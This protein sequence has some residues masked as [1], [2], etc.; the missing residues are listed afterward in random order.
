[1]DERSTRTLGLIFGHMKLESVLDQILALKKA[2]GD[3]G[4]SCQIGD[5]YIDFVHLIDPYCTKKA[6]F[7]DAELMMF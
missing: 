3:I 2:Y 5:A 1:V 7:I 6:P 4:R